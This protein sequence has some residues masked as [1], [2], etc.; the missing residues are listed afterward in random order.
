MVMKWES[1]TVGD[2]VHSDL[3]ADQR[4]L[5]VNAGIWPRHARH[6]NAER[7]DLAIAISKAISFA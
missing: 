7:L 3:A 5:A 6:G 4:N 1:W 2:G